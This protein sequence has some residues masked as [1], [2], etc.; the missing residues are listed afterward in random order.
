MT[1]FGVCEKGNY[2]EENQDS[3]L[4]C[5]KGR[6]GLFIVA[7][8]VGGSDNGAA[9]SRYIT[10]R[11]RQWWK[12]EFLKI[13]YKSFFNCF[14]RIKKLADQINHSIYNRYGEGRSCST[15]VLLFVHKGIYGY[16]SA[17]DSRIY[18]CSRK[19][20][21]IITRDDIWE[22]CPG[23]D[24]NSIHA[25]KIVSAVGGFEKLEYSCATD[26]THL[27]EV[28]MLCSDGIYKYVEEISLKISMK[29]MYRKFFLQESMVNKLAKKASDNDTKDNY[30]LV[31]VKV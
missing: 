2:R 12:E 23:A 21:R 9:A 31:V 16:L 5:S 24:L 1:G 18:H 15:I 14:N 25:G 29:N 4:I 20:F 3:I 6:S 17:G 27:G 22:N 7:D 10:D 13:R 28:F 26:K 8:G 11:Y 19:E 30:S